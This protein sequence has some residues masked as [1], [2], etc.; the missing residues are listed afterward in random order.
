MFSRNFAVAAFAAACLGGCVAQAPDLHVSARPIF[1][2]PLVYP[3]E[4]VMLGIE[5]HVDVECMVTVEGKS[6][7]CDV[8]SSTHPVFTAAA[9]S[10]VEAATY[11]PAVRAGMPV[12]ERHTWRIDFKLHE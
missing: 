7:D 11:H 1:G 3:A 6:R 5:G 8:V 4:M 2:Q 12:E 10:Y 9:L